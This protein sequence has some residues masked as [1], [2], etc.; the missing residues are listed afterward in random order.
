MSYILKDD[1]GEIQ[2]SDQ[3]GNYI[4]KNSESAYQYEDWDLLEEVENLV[5][6]L[7]GRIPVGIWRIHIAK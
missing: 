6:K 7:L 2:V 4:R 3:Y 1:I 5:K